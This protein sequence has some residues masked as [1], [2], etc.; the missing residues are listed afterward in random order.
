MKR[1]PLKISWK[2]WCLYKL[3]IR[4]YS[5]FEMK[6]MILKRASESDQEVDPVPLINELIKDGAINDERYLKNQLAIATND[7]Q[8]KGPREVKRK[9]IDKGGLSEELINVYFNENDSI[10]F[11]LA[12]KLKIQTLS[13]KGLTTLDSRAIPIKLF[14]SLKQKLYRKGFTRE[15][16]NHAMA[17]LVPEYEQ[18][19]PVVPRDLERQV[20]KLR[21]SGKGPKAI[22]YEL[23]QKGA[24]EAE[25]QAILDK[26]DVDWIE[27]AMDQVER[28]YGS[29]KK[30]THKERKKRFDFLARKGYTTDQIRVALE[31]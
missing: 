21:L 30:L 9:M 16:I 23:K 31:A 2:S 10:W 28:K 13:A 18:K 8:I 7:Q 12:E 24:K 4:D 1:K 17:N 5:S 3:A 22:F 19:E 11:Q 27:Q 6:Q 20:E 26:L 14:T 29:V 25:I 15:Q